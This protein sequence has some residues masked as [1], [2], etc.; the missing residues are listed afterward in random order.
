MA[1]G[2]QGPDIVMTTRYATASDL[3]AVSEHEKHRTPDGSSAIDPSRSHL[4]EV[5][6]GPE[7][8]Q[9]ALEDLYGSGVKRPTAQAEA[10]FVQMVLSAS[11]AFF[12]AEGRGPG[13]WDP[14][15]LREWKGAT[16]E[17]LRSEFG[18]DLVHVSLHLDED[19]P[20][21]HVLL[22]P[23]YEK[24]ARKPGKPKRG[25]TSE[26]FEARKRAA[27]MADTVR[28]VGRS[29]NEYWSRTWA[30]RDARISY[31]DAMKILGLGY[32]KDF[33]GAG[34][35]SP[36]R[37][38]TGAWV[39]EQAALLKEE[40][41]EV[42]RQLDLLDRARASVEA[43]RSRLNLMAERL[44]EAR[45]AAEDLL[46]EVRRRAG[47]PAQLRNGL[48]DGLRELR[49]ALRPKKPLSEHERIVRDIESRIPE[50]PADPFDQPGP[51]L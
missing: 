17:W 18:P 33:A 46:A 13:E 9:D 41:Q 6:I 49:E 12:R 26:E 7:T 14:D 28:C 4:N 32:G 22:V 27:E 20:H 47:L 43:E 31:F 29:S 36:E 39:R 24:R 42:A 25:E 40:R 23:T 10:P 51:G 16:L 3:R 48:L 2:R 37:K 34:E 8:Q 1:H 50:R 35:P 19:T 21:M 5:L 45:R 44:N 11:P 30:R 38:D 15:R